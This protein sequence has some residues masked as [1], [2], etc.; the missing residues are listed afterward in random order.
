MKLDP[1]LP[2]LPT[3]GELL[4]HPRVK[5]VVERINRSTLAQRATGF[6]DELRASLVERAG[7]FEVPSVTQLAER[8]ARRLLGEPVA[9][10]PVINATGIVVGDPQLMPPLADAA[11]QAMM[12]TASEYHGVGEALR[13]SAEE[14]L[15]ELT[16]AEAALITGSFDAALTLV[17]SAVANN[18]EFLVCGV[19]EE[20]TDGIEWP[21]FAARAGAV[22]KR[23]SMQTPTDIA[24]SKVAAIVRAPE[25][26][27]S[28]SLKELISSDGG[29]CLID[30]APLAGLHNPSLYGFDS[31]E[32][33]GDRLTAGADI[34]VANGA[35]LLGGPS[36]GIIVG[37]TEYIKSAAGHP[38]ASLVSLDACSTAALHA[39]LLSY[40][41]DRDLSFA[42]TIP[43][44]Q[45]LSAPRANG[46]QRAERLAP[47]M[48]AIPGV[49]RAEAC[50]T[51]SP[52]R[53]GVSGTA[54]APSW[55]IAVWPKIVSASAL[56][57]NLQRQPYPVAA[58]I[59]GDAVQLDL[60]AVYPRW[61]QQLVA[62]VE[63]SLA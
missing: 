24:K 60:R 35:G 41:N 5:G 58:R 44:W 63:H 14:M 48:A 25:A 4:E 1:H 16:G 59:A 9:A 43:L 20:L 34:V 27:H 36:C 23:H 50:E 19:S 31:I 57:D 13:H 38:L 56:L 47:L 22:Y 32:T 2:Q 51:H 15:R 11:V 37:K 61:D 30:A 17:L 18:K 26:P 62:A 46:K 12:Q 3:I 33:L 8:L 49:A 40:K 29:T 52:W 54:Q 21:W 6:L 39:T 7:N 45:L 55:A 53:K 10:R 42:F 28:T